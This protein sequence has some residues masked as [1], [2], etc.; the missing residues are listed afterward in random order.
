ME[1]SWSTFLLE[2]INF[3]VLVWIL[4]RFLFKPVMA[5]ISQRQAD[6]DEQLA[7]SQRLNDESAALKGEYENRLANWKEQCQLAREE[8]NKEIDAERASRLELLAQSMEQEKEKAEVAESRQR[9]EAIREREQQA[10]QQSARFAKTLLSKASGPEL[11]SRLLNILLDDLTSLSHDNAASLLLQW[12]VLPE[13]IEISSAYPIAQN[14]RQEL[15]KAL[16]AVS[17]L[18]IPVRYDE[19]PEL[20]AGLLITIGAWCLRANI[21]DDLKGF[22]E[23]AYV[24]R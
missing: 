9:M 24:T 6:I 17:Q 23:F 21:R 7:Q 16:A 10:L 8:L 13:V 5:V 20:I 22:T 11:E 12:G 1:F 18:S 15:E 4:K 14:K 3:L 2:V 19:D